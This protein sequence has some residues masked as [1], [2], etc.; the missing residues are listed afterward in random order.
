M[1]ILSCFHILT[2][3]NNAAV[4]WGMQISLWD[5]AFNSS[6]YIAEVELLGHMTILFL[7]FEE[8]PYTFPQWL[9]HFTFLWIAHKH[10]SFSPSSS[11][12]FTFC[13]V[14]SNHSNGYD[15]IFHCSFD[16]HF[17]NDKWCKTSSYVLSGHLHVF[18]E[19][20]SIQVFCPYWIGSFDFFVVEF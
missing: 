4:N 6:E 9:H 15:V 14:D 16:L 2:V 5:S 7:F 17:L 1:D 11:T 10:S 19:E 3:I 18:F 8:S 12:L 20:M 13:F